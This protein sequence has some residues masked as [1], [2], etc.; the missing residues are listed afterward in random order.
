MGIPLETYQQIEAG[1]AAPTL[2]Q[3]EA[4]A[5][6][7]D[8]SLEHFWGNQ[9]LSTL[10]PEPVDQPPQ[11]KELRQRII[12]TRLRMARSGLNLSVTELALRTNITPEK[13]SRYET[14]A[15]AIPLPDLEI[16]ADAMQIGHQELFD[17]RGMIGKWHT[18]KAAVKNIMELPDEVRSFIS[19]PVNLPY[20]ELAIRLSDL[21]V[22]KLRSVA[23]GLLEITY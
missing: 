4:L 8:V 5:Y 20:L 2:P 15:E 12:G 13:I 19:K 14:G 21:S 22:D 17:Q 23:E 11:L 3:L 18:D 9:T 1:E 7:L 16:L 6:Y 10:T